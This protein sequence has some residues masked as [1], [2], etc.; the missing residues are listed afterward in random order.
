MKDI[1][2]LVL[3]ANIGI[4]PAFFFSFFFIRWKLKEL[5][6]RYSY[7]M[8]LNDLERYFSKWKEH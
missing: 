7:E 5:N 1:I 6:R 8:F 4:I 3:G 2:L